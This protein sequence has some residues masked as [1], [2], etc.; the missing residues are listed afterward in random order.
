[1]VF[2]QTDDIVSVLLDHTRT[3]GPSDARMRFFSSSIHL[4][5]L[6]IID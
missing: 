1:M 2:A 6:F 3:R 4:G 5:K